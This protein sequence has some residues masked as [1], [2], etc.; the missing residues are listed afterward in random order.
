VTT[1]ES[2]VFAGYLDPNLFGWPALRLS[3]EGQ[4]KSDRVQ[5][6]E[7]GAEVEEP[8]VLRTTRVNLGSVATELA[9]NWFETFRT[10]AKYRYTLVHPL[11]PR[12]E[13]PVAVAAQLP[14]TTQTDATL[15]FAAGIDTRQNLGPLLEGLNLEGSY[16]LSRAGLGS[17]FEYEKLG[18]LYR[19]GIRLFEEQNL[20]LRAEAQLGV[21]LPFYTELTTGGGNLRGF[22]HRQFRGD[23]KGSLTAEY[24][25]PLFRVSPL[26]VRG[27][28]FSDTALTYFRNI[29]DDGVRLGLNGELVRRYLPNQRE[30]LSGGQLTQG[31]GAGVRL[32]LSNI[33]LPLLGVDVA[34]GVNPGAVRV[35]VVAGV[36]P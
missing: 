36:S 34:Y 13:D 29:P 3:I 27:V 21:D 26:A 23:T 18:V 30:G 7:G 16:E 6:Y 17:D 10:A 5:E 35:Y 28:A 14:R 2:G 15:R 1:N 32:Y 31:V 24:H 22:L 25:F 12:Q 8:L 20:V 11:S 19:H 33:V 4:F 9:I